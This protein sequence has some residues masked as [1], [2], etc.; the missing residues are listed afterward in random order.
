MKKQTTNK[1]KAYEIIIHKETF[2]NKKLTIP[3]KKIEKNVMYKEDLN[4]NRYDFFNFHIF[5]KIGISKN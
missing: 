3:S 2:S 4:A 5:K 1:T